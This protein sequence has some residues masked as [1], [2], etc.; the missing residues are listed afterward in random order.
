M[1]NEELKVWY[2][3]QYCERFDIKTLEEADLLAE[4]ELDSAN[5]RN[6]SGNALSSNLAPTGGHKL[7][8][9][10]AKSQLS[11][12]QQNQVSLQEGNKSQD[13]LVAA[14]DELAQ[15][16]MQDLFDSS[17]ASVSAEPIIS[18]NLN[19]NVE[20]VNAKNGSTKGNITSNDLSG[21][22]PKTNQ[23]KCN[24]CERVFPRHYSLRRHLVMHSGMIS[25][26]FKYVQ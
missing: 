7:R 19:K 3:N 1:P 15:N 2:S 12:L 14:Q 10:I 25:L 5:G 22:D 23:Y 21:K 17:L 18:D 8:N 16:E 24:I 9:K 26:F 20:I 6:N 4:A 11:Q 13:Q